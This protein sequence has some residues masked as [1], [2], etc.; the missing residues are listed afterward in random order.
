IFYLRDILDSLALRKKIQPGVCIAIIGAGF[1]GLEIAAIARKQGAI[2]IVL[3]R[4]PHVLARVAA[5]EVGAYLAA[6]HRAN[7]VEIITGVTLTSIEDI[8]SKL[9]IHA[10]D[11]SVFIADIAAVGI[12]SIPNAELAATA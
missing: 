3:E 6:L 12:G 10:A 2:V 7:G 1:I 8:G 5:P 11:G 4:A 9:H